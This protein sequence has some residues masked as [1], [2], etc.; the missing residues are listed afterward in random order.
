MLDAK[1]MRDQICVVGVGN[2]SYGNFPETDAYGLGIE[3]LNK[4]LDDAGLTL[5]DVDGMIVNRIPSYERFSE[6]IGLRNQT[7][8]LQLP[9]S[10]RMSAVSV[11][12]AAAALASG[13]AKCIALVYGNNGRSVRDTYGGGETTAWAP[14][15]FTS[16]GARHAMMFRRHMELYGTTSEQ[17]AH[18]A[19][20]FRGHATL[21]PDAVMRKPISI[22]EHQ[23]SR[24]IAEPLR[25]LDYCLIN[26]GGVALI[27]T[28]ADRAK[29]MRKKP[30][31]ISAMGRQDDYVDST[32]FTAS[33]DL[34]YTPLSRI[35]AHIYDDAGV[36]RADVDALMVYDNFTPTVVFSL[37]GMGF[38]K[39]GE[40][41]PF[42]EEGHLALG[43]DLPTNTS[44]GHLSESYMQGWALIGE[45]VRQ[46]RGECGER[47]VVDCRVVQYICA[48]TI[49][50]SIIFR[51]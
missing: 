38:C 4:A 22:A 20:A 19:T 33:D 35:A 36:S 40:G 24:F 25:L 17:L 51:S 28:T 15:G 50:A 13:Q 48:T 32:L 3:A 31:H 44:G 27:L 46:A 8:G 18:I 37:E 21:N 26:D 16:P 10:G 23:S 6:M 14:W 39:R 5:D 1:G 2:T 45:A 49:C 47:Q 30:V 7:F 29:D 11:M 42:A 41:G 43:S 34:W 12:T 9:A